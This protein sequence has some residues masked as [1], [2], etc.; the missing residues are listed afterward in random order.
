MILN[1]SDIDKLL[2]SL[3][4]IETETIKN[5]IQLLYNKGLFDN[6]PNKD[7]VFEQYITFSDEY[8]NEKYSTDIQTSE[9][10]Y[11]LSYL[12]YS[13][14]RKNIIKALKKDKN[15][16]IVYLKYYLKLP[17]DEINFILFSE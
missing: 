6:F 9:G 3:E 7:Q 10:L 11:Y 12:N 5:V 16:D 4:S 17:D 1:Q 14:S 8:L 13:E 2:N 15:S